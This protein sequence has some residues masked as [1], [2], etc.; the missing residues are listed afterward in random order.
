MSHEPIRTGGGSWAVQGCLFGAVALFVVLLLTMIFLAYGRFR[1]HTAAPETP[2]SWIT[3]AS[4]ASPVAP[5]RAHPN[6][7]SSATA[8]LTVDR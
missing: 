8:F 4:P 1:D 7:S 5:A 6:G 2:T 3:P